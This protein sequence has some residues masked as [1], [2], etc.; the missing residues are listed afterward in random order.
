MLSTMES[1]LLCFVPLFVAVD[2]IGVLPMYLGLVEGL[3]PAEQRS[4]ISQSIATAMIVALLF[5]FVGEALFRFLDITAADFMLSGGALL[6]VISLSDILL[7]RKLQR[8]VEPE[9]IGVVPLGVPLIVGPAVLTSLILLSHR[10]GQV[11]TAI[12]V[13]I[14]ILLGGVIFWFADNLNRVLG[15]AGMRAC[16]KIASLI[17]AAI[18]VRMMREGLVNFLGR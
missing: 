6:F 10:Y 8:Q 13:V 16:S 18:A 1:F 9:S 17:L 2:A 15:K 12:A 5:L 14:N 3:A 4:I 11:P 7:G